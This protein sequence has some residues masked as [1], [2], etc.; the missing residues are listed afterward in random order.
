MFVIIFCKKKRVM[1]VYSFIIVGVY[2]R[3][4]LFILWLG[5][6]REEVEK[7]VFIIIFYKDKF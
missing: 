6:R 5:G 7:R 4:K 1:L 3:I 2:D